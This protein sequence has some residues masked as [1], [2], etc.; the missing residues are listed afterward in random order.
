MHNAIVRNYLNKKKI[1]ER[2]G[3]AAASFFFLTQ[4]SGV[5]EYETRDSI[6]NIFKD[7]ESSLKTH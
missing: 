3:K 2:L 5:M 4:N 1:E 7:Q 6:L